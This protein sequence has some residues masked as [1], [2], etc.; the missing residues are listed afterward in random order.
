[1]NFSNLCQQFDRQKVKQLIFGVLGVNMAF[2]IAGVQY[3]K[4]TTMKYLNTTTGE[5]EFFRT[6]AGFIMI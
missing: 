2:L 5:Q 6:T 1:M 4:I 3:E